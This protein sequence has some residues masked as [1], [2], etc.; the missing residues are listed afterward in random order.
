MDIEVPGFD[1]RGYTLAFFAVRS[2]LEPEGR[3]GKALAD[4]QSVL[5]KRGLVQEIF[6]PNTVKQ[7][8]EEGAPPLVYR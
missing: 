1:G 7:M 2:R 4:A 8:R 6:Q 3:Y 5:E